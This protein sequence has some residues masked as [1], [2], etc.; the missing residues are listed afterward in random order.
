MCGRQV[1]RTIQPMPTSRERVIDASNVHRPWPCCPRARR[2]PDSQRSLDRECGASVPKPPTSSS[3]PR[4]ESS[5]GVSP[6]GRVAI[7]VQRAPRA[8]A[9]LTSRD[10]R[11]TSRQLSTNRTVHA[12]S[13]NSDADFSGNSGA[14]TSRNSGRIEQPPSGQRLAVSNSEGRDDRHAQAAR[15]PGSATRRAQSTRGRDARR[16]LTSKRTTRRH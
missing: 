7:A 6:A 9:A 2:H 4:D 15:N 11:V 13:G 12:G 5:Q 1:S 8:A 16:R 10:K 14:L 3:D